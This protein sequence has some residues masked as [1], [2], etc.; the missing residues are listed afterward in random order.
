MIGAPDLSL[1]FFTSSI[2][3]ML[4]TLP[5]VHFSLGNR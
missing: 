3:I 5:K 2:D 4:R 1:S